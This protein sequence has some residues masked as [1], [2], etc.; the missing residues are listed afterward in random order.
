MAVGF[1]LVIDCADPDLLARFWVTA[2]GYELEPP[3]T[4]FT[5]WD[6]YWRDV[7]VPEADLGIGADRIIDPDGGGPRHLVPGG[8]RTQ[9]HQE[10]APPRRPRQRRAGGPDRNPQAASRR[11]GT[12]ASDLG[13]TMVGVLSQESIDH[14]AVAMKDPRA[15]NS[16]S[17][18]GSHSRRDVLTKRP[19]EDAE[20]SPK[21]RKA[22][23]PQVLTIA[24]SAPVTTQG[25][26]GGSGCHRRR[27]V[28]AG[29][30]PRLSALPPEVGREPPRDSWRLRCAPAVSQ[31]HSSWPGR[32]GS[33][34]RAGHL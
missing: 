2:L 29:G 30:S 27:V 20:P 23:D 18:D 4:G 11:R 15:T 8:A 34:R 10:P 33:S 9:D 5:S 12:T 21:P 7:G 14:Y 1:Q 3:P 25:G 19:G 24:P 16:T 32:S 6:D 26:G 31:V 22:L 13:A 28:S 17:T